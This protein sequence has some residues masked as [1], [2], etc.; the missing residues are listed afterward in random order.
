M[1]KYPKA[2]VIL[3]LLLLAG[4]L[5]LSGCGTVAD[6]DWTPAPSTESDWI[7]DTAAPE[8]V[9]Y[10]L[11]DTAE[12]SML[13][14]DTGAG[15]L[16]AA[17]TDYTGIR[18]SVEFVSLGELNERLEA[19]LAAQDLPDLLEPYDETMSFTVRPGLAAAVLDLTDYVMTCAPNYL[20]AMG[21]NEILKDH[22]LDDGEI[23]TFY[24]LSTGSAPTDYGPWIRQDW[25]EEQGLEIPRT[26]EDYETAL[27]AFR[28]AYGCSDALLLP[29]YGAIEGNYLA[30]GFGAAAWVF[31]GDY[32][33]MGFYVQDGVVKYGPL[34]PGFWDYVT[35]LH[36]WYE[37]GLI[38][39]DFMYQSPRAA[40][41][42]SQT[43]LLYLTTGEAG[44]YQAITGD[45]SGVL[46]PIPD[47]ALTPDDRLHL[48]RDPKSM[49][50]RATYY[51]P[52]TCPDPALAVRWCDFWYTDSGTRLL[53]W[54]VEG[55]TYSL[56]ESGQP[57]YTEAVLL[58]S[59]SRS[60]RSP[61]LCDLL[62]GVLDLDLYRYWL[63][64]PAMAA[65]D[66]W[67]RGRDPA[68]GLSADLALSDQDKERF[69][70][71]MIAIQTHTASLTDQL[72]TGA[73]SLD[74]RETCLQQ[75][76]D[77]G[78]DKCIACLQAYIAQ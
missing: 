51:V 36:H 9:T 57:V 38:S 68:W 2:A 1:P 22:L 25:L 45:G 47:A 4:M 12:L 75:L 10:P 74:Q 44:N 28:D 15:E 70:N 76:R 17:S 52:A 7:F 46:V 23:N 27:V 32:S 53:N 73:K 71:M 33:N 14:A 39:P 63:D 26:Y 60:R 78:I 43:G 16:L 77:L 3:S 18:L 8:L 13:M 66:T 19:M 72:I 31:G 5:A 37:L 56:D 11:A 24:Q 30:A 61:Y 59:G 21:Q 6:Q 50:Q 40:L 54:G 62:P 55:E 69:S 41:V 49:V 34:E 35:L 64:A 29:G 20:A 65:S 42:G 58:A 67:T 48:A